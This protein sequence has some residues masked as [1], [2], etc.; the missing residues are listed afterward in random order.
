MKIAFFS[1]KKFEP[2]YFDEALQTHSI[3]YFTEPLDA[4]HAHLIHKHD[5]VCIFVNDT[6]DQRCVRMLKTKQVKI[7]ALRCSGYNNV[8]LRACKKA[9]IK[10]VYVPKYSPHAVAE[11]TVALLLC[12]NR[13][14]HKAYNRVKEGNFD[15]SGLQGFELYKKTI[16]IIGL[17]AI[18]QVV[19][20]I[21]H[22]FGCNIIGCDPIRTNQD[23]IQWHNLASLLKKSDIICIHCPG[24]KNNYHLINSTNLQLLQKHAL[25]LNTAR[26][27]LLDTKALIAALKNNQ[28][29]G[30]AL[31]VYEAERALF[32]Q[33]N[34]MNI[35]QDDDLMRLISLPNVII[36]SHQGFLTHEALQ[37]IAII[38]NDNL[39]TINKGR[40]CLN[41]LS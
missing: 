1:T 8:D 20:D 16:G 23:F 26:G 39:E 13:K 29:A 9:H 36:T 28:L 40:I 2:H 15:I 21:F 37:K 27:E 32:F 14:I 5:V 3:D 31:D 24:N 41:Q 34:S 17:G 7:I 12:L 22:G 35:I 18:G 38:T 11:H 10:V 4:E 30:A 25:L 33:D 6:V 19:A